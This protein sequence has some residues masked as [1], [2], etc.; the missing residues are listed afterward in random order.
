[1]A[2]DP[3]PR[4]ISKM[5]RKLLE[6]PACSSGLEGRT[7]MLLQKAVYRRVLLTEKAKKHA[8]MKFLR[9]SNKLSTL[10]LYAFVSP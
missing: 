2:D 8:V 9:N 6:P 3:I 4:K 10:V 5:D 1:M 7:Y